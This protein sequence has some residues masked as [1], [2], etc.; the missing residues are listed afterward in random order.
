MDSMEQ[1]VTDYRRLNLTG[2]IIDLYPVHECD[3]A[4]IVRM[5]NHTKMMYYLH[6]AQQLTV[7]GEM[8]PCHERGVPLHPQKHRLTKMLCM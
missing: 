5:R 7:E 8:R 1:A 4:D 6:Q 2:N 3:L